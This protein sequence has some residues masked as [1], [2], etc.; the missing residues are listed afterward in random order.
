MT[1][2]SP[3]KIHA[4]IIAIMRAIG[5]IAKE[6]RNTQQNYNFRGV[7]Q[8]YNAVYPHLCE[9][10]VYSTSEIMAEKHD[11][12]ISN[13]K[14][15]IHSILTMRFTYHAEDGSSVSTEV[16]GEGTDYGGDK[17]SNKAMSVADKYAL[18]QLLKIPTAMVDPDREGPRT[19][20]DAARQ[21]PR[22]ERVTGD[23]VN[24]AKNR[25]KEQNP[26][27]TLEDFGKWVAYTTEREFV[28]TKPGEWTVADYQ[29]VNRALD[30]VQS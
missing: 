3:G 8:I 21:Q 19:N 20:P 17:A 15:V 26:K 27:G 14:T 24:A 12:F 1:E 11:N 5:P 6:L 16:V 13:G 25:W 18:L 23:M 7:D 4:A 9:Y 29:R 2:P 10:G 30:G 28:V 22:G